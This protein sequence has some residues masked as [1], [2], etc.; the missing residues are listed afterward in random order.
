M[1]L[2]VAVQAETTKHLLQSCIMEELQATLQQVNNAA[3]CPTPTAAA[4]ICHSPGPHAISLTSSLNRPCLRRSSSDRDCCSCAERR[5][6]DGDTALLARRTLQCNTQGI[7]YAGS[8][9]MGWLWVLLQAAW[10]SAIH[11][12]LNVVFISPGSWHTLTTR[13]VSTH[14][15]ACTHGITGSLL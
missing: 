1:P 14:D 7:A 12:P 15:E 8:A 10:S 13:P 5:M 6:D 3:G 2:L 4:G 11:L 9:T